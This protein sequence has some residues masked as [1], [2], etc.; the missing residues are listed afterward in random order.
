MKLGDV[1]AGRFRVEEA[2]G[3]GGM[4]VVYRAVD[5]RSG[6]FVAVKVL[7]D[8]VFAGHERFA[9]EVAALAKLSHP[10]IV[11]YIDHGTGFVVMEWLVGEDLSERLRRGALG[12]EDAVSVAMS[13]AHA[14]AHAHDQGIVH[15]DIKP[16]NVFFE[17]GDLARLRLIDFGLAWIAGD[18]SDFRTSAGVTVGTPGYMA[19]EQV[20][21][22]LVD[23]RADVFALGCLLYKCLTG[24]GPFAGR[25]AIATLAKVLFDDPAPASTTNPAI[26]PA[27]DAILMRALSKEVGMRQPSARAFAAELANLD[28]TPSAVLPDRPSSLTN[29]ELRVVSVVVAARELF[30]HEGETLVQRVESEFVERQTA[31]RAAAA[32][33][34]ARIEILPG[35]IVAI[36]HGRGSATDLAI[37]ASRF[38]LEMRALLPT[39]PIALATG[40]AELGQSIVGDVIERAVARVD[41]M[42]DLP[43][44]GRHDHAQRANAVWIDE[45]T[46][47]LLGPAFTVNATDAGLE[48]VAERVADE[49]SVELVRTL[50]GKP[51][52]CVGRETWIAA[53]EASFD[54]AVEQ[55]EAR[56]AVVVAGAGVGKSRVRYEVLR[57]LRAKAPELEV[58]HARGDVIGAGSA[59]LLAA[60]MIRGAAGIQE[61]EAIATRL[62]KLAARVARHVPAAW[63]ERVTDFLGELIGTPTP[64]AGAQLEAA[65]R[66]AIVMGDQIRRAWEDFID[67]EAAAHPL[68]LVLEDLHWGDS[69]TV[70]MV[71]NV[72]RLSERRPLFVLALGR[73]EIDTL[74]PDLW[75][76]RN[77]E[78]IELPALPRIAAE[79]L[80]KTVLGADS[81]D[82][83]RVVDRAAGNAFYLEELIRAVF[84][85]RGDK[86]PDTVLGTVE[87]RITALDADERK[88]LRAASV[89]GQTFWMDGVRAL[90]GRDAAATLTRLEHL[91]LVVRRHRGRLAEQAE[92][93]FRHALV[94]EA[95]YAMLVDAD[96]TLGHK[97][98]AEWLEQNGETDALAIAEHLERA[99]DRVRAADAFG[100]AARQA[101]EANDFGEALAR[102]ERGASLGAQGTALGR[103]RLVQAEA[104]RWRAEFPPALERAEQAMAIFE[105]GSN[106]WG[107]AAAELSAAAVRVG[108]IDRLVRV[109]KEVLAATSGGTAGVVASAVRASTQLTF[110]GHAD[111]AG[112]LLDAVSGHGARATPMLQAWISEARTVRAIHA[113]NPALYLGGALATAEAFERAGDARSACNQRVNAGYAHIQL[114][115]YAEGEVILRSAL[116]EA[117]RMHLANITANAKQNLG[118]ALFHLGRI[119]E[120]MRMVQE[121]LRACLEN[122]NRRMEV[123]SRTYVA[124]ILAHQGALAEAEEEART[125]SQLKAAPPLRPLALAVLARCLLAQQRFNDALTVA[126]EAIEVLES[127]GGAAEEG[128]TEARLVYAETLQ[129]TGDHAGS[130]AAL[131]DARTRLLARADKIESERWR[132]SFLDK[133]ENARTL[134]LDHGF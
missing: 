123:G 74:F 69:G 42:D 120:G 105:R 1:V 98:A 25:D 122:R 92:L 45:T 103:L 115:A 107:E 104:H 100:R 43:T 102:A 127:L 52:A 121:S 61:G 39:V 6:T 33:H 110:A 124:A 128:E 126:R 133:P 53:I 129:R 116:A 60:Q 86:L 47:S 66:D 17:N 18:R 111:L 32:R 101:I 83:A 11:R 59:F 134:A 79:K 41:T 63:Q 37:A 10:A 72:L 70:A 80:A 113:G 78:R 15:R 131:A 14:V 71:D 19:P 65:R 130:I 30:G 57:R 108:N 91:E 40:R 29:R 50:C 84:E 12:I 99:G 9:R 4:G 73:P 76:E 94:R 13:L 97:L 28:L 44:L 58:W 68:A 87:A 34:D 85:G 88:A 109:G 5:I 81:L 31:L 77:V 2:V 21:G 75:G 54:A 93:V 16:S 96:R 125:A 24:Y 49:R 7:N 20:R 117:E 67:A 38:A 95:A 26:P 8:G 114:G 62:S 89:F 118:W 119:D 48:L 46:A 27:L 35:A 90:A 132:K 36:M 3:E 22:E 55:P 112:A 51:T 82:I 106:A 23:A 56:A 64:D